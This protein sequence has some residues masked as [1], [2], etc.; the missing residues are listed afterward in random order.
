VKVAPARPSD[1]LAAA[2]DVQKLRA[3]FPILAREIN[4]Y[5][6][7]YLDSAASAQTPRQVLDAMD[8]VYEHHYANVHRGV[9][10][11]A[12]EATDAYEAARDAVARFVQAN[13]RR[14][15]I[16]VRNATE[17]LNLVAYSYGGASCGP[18]DVIVCS[19]MEHHSNMVPWQLLAHRTGAS[20]RYIGVTADGRLDLDQLAAIGREGRVR[21]VAV[22]HQSNT[23]GTLN[24]VR[25][26]CDW[27][28]ERDAVVVVDGAQSAP[29]RPVDVQA[30]G[31]DFFAFSGHKLPGPSGAGAL[32]ARE[33]L[34][35]NMPPFMSGG[36]MIQSV[37]LERT[38]FNALPWKFEAGTPAI[39][40][41]V[42]LGA[43]I[44][45]LEA[46]G[47]D[48]VAAHEAELTKYACDRLSA[49][50]GLTILGPPAADRGG[51][52]SFTFEPAHPHDV[53]QIVDRR[54][55]CVRAGHHCTQPLMKR[56]GVPAT[57]R[58]SFYLYTVPEE[59]DRL[60]DGLEDVRELFA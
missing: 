39:V 45:Y 38:S 8:H 13:S 53:A 41:C 7:A 47:M 18:G 34:L 14:E 12:A 3:D 9:Y 20:L 35:K 43:S 30:L 11:I 58:A 19:E 32:W 50:E 1:P 52:V 29:H 21:L 5:P 46:I 40:E 15:C 59:I 23:L 27:A 31:C 42:G 56:F 6:L 10:T 57:T 2:L 28:H 25:E 17:A 4:G 54:G 51:V 37:E 22:V 60:C 55:V 16:F 44:D 33:E 26:I 36:E 48:A 49:V 24:P